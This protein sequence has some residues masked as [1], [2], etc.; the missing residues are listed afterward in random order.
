[1]SR[2]V[3]LSG[4]AVAVAALILAALVVGEQ[5]L[6]VADVLAALTGRDASPAT[7]MIVTGFR[8]PRALLAALVGAALAVAGAVSQAVMRNPLAEPGL[9]GI[10]AGAALAAL[11]VLVLRP[12]TPALWLPWAASAGALAM[13]LA[14]YALSWRGGASSARIILIGIGLSALAGA[15]AGMITAFGEV[16]AV[17]RAMVWLSGSLADSRW[18]RVWT[19]AGW[20]VLPVAFVLLSARELD[21]LAYSD[22]TAR[23]LGQ[24]VELA[25][26]LM[27][28][29]CTLISG[30]AVAAAG[31]IGFVGLI[32]PHLAR[33]LAGPRHGGSVPLAALLGAVLVLAADILGRTVIAP[34]ELPAG[35]VTALIGAPFFGWLM[36]RARNG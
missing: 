9:L 17:Q 23:S 36:W 1:M 28:L 16:S 21:L 8:L 35:I 25:R 27:M 10:N 29:G 34:A 5:A 31:L 22:D 13:A 26:A 19:T 33:R 3:V 20:L 11:C 12:A 2:P 24:R 4:A 18:I 15:G 30:A 6:P 7:A 14:I 32:A